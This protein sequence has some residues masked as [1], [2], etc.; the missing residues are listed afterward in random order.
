[1][2]TIHFGKFTLAYYKLS[3]FKRNKVLLSLIVCISSFLK[4]VL[5]F[6]F[7]V[8]LG[9][10]CFGKAFSSCDGF[11]SYEAQALQRVVFSSCGPRAQKL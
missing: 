4:L 10:H 9:L 11:S 7:F 8:T 1:M 5:Y 6:L 3:S 2:K